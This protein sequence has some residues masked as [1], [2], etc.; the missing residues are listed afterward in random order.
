MYFIRC[1]PLLL[2]L[3]CSS[4]QAATCPGPESTL[5]KQLTVW[6]SMHGS[7]EQ[8]YINRYMD[9]PFWWDR[10]S[11]E[12]EDASFNARDEIVPVGPAHTRENCTEHESTTTT[13]NTKT[14]SVT[15]S[16]SGTKKEEIGGE[17]GWDDAGTLK[18]GL[19]SSF[20]WEVSG[21]YTGSS[22]I[23]LTGT[24]AN[25]KYYAWPYV[26]YA[27]RK[28]DRYVYYTGPVKNW[29]VTHSAWGISYP[30]QTD[31]YSTEGTATTKYINE[32]GYHEDECNPCTCSISWTG[33]TNPVTL[34]GPISYTSGYNFYDD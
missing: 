28:G 1:F 29:C 33:Y 32:N 26:G 19:A 10:C 17:L 18:F 25:T 3:S 11:W 4:A 12:Y 22:S 24:P 13:T 34:P 15:V 27:Y 30:D 2:I 20:T 7:T 6:G 14:V 16:L 5:S 8:H 23:E 9:Y 21:T 31:Y